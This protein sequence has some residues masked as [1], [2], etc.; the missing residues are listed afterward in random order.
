MTVGEARL[1]A[2]LAVFAAYWGNIIRPD[3]PVDAMTLSGVIQK[4]L[5]NGAFDVIAWLLVLTRQWHARAMEPARL[6]TILRVF[7]LGTIVLLPNRLSA[8]VAAGLLGAAFLRDPG[9]AMRKSGLVLCG[10]AATNLWTSPL[11]GPLHVLVGTFDARVCA[12]LLRLLGQ[13]ATAEANVVS[14]ATSHFGIMVWPFCASSFPLGDVALAFVVTLQI[15]RQPWRRAFV[16][17]FALSVATSVVLTEI[18]LVLLAWNEAGYEWWHQ[19]PGVSLYALVAL[20]LAMAFPWLAAHRPTDAARTG[21][22]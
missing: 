5:D 1:W 14:N 19:G 3:G 18:R 10:L 15:L 4:I 2:I 7:A 8:T 11:L 12:A 21:A 6:G 17:L 9:V 22:A 16:P 20:G 13:D